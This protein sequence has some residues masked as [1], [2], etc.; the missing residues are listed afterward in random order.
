MRGTLYYRPFPVVI[1]SPSGGGKSTV[2][3]RLL[4]KDS[5]LRFSVTCTTRKPRPGEINGRH[6]YFLSEDE[7]KAALRGG[8]LL[9]WARVHGNFYGTPLKPM[10]EALKK[11]I[12]PVM[13]I[14][15]QG[16]RSVKKRIPEAVTIFLLPPGWKSL[17]ERLLKRKEGAGDIRIRLATAR[18]EMRRV[19]DYDYAVVNDRLDSAVSDILAIISAERHKVARKSRA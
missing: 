15:V 18:R 7:F 9:E 4:K 19:E 12:S 14:D 5:R 1:S 6:Y 8:R 3:G 16:A 10:R 17:R 13:I 11:G 2:C